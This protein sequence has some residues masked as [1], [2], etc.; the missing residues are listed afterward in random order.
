MLNIYYPTYIIIVKKE[1]KMNTQNRPKIQNKQVVFE[2]LW[3]TY[4]NDILYAKGLI[5]EEQRNKMRV[6][7]KTRSAISRSVNMEDLK[8][9]SSSL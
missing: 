5:T 6:K 1:N 4:F 8:P 2:Q 3:L 7:I 9:K